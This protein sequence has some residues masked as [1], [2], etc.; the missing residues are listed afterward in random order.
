MCSGRFWRTSVVRVGIALRGG[1]G[2]LVRGVVVEVD[3]V[4]DCTEDE[5][6]EGDM[7]GG[8]GG[9]IVLLLDIELEEEEDAGCWRVLDDVLHSSFL[10]R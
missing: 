6:V 1:G 9:A 8:G 3:L 5:G 7:S 4:E 2:A 10:R